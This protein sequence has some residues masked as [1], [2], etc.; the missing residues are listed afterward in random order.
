MAVGSK[1]SGVL[2]VVVIVVVAIGDGLVGEAAGVD[3]GVRV[4]VG[5]GKTSGAG[6]GG[7]TGWHAL[8]QSKKKIGTTFHVWENQ[9]HIIRTVLAILCSPIQSVITLLALV[10]ASRM[11]DIPP[12]IP[13]RTFSVSPK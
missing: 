12:T 7:E 2:G 6:K 10:W 1:V 11:S 8:P 3:S 13:T 4:F 9:R 5:D